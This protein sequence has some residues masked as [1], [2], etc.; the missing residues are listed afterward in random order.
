MLFQFK[1][2][3]K[4]TNLWFS[5]WTH[6][7]TVSSGND[8]GLTAI[9]SNTMSNKKPTP[10]LQPAKNGPKCN[11]PHGISKPMKQHH[12]AKYTE[13]NDNKKMKAKNG[14]KCNTPGG[15]SKPTK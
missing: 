14:P 6:Q 10:D 12:K 2:Y 15:I 13:T 1:V 3:G 9:T 4:V 5:H 11:T 7:P 8:Q